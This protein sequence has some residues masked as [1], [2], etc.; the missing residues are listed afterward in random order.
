[1]LTY[2]G[3]GQWAHS[4][5]PGIIIVFYGSDFQANLTPIANEASDLENGN[6]PG[7]VKIYLKVF[8]WVIFLLPG[9]DQGL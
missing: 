4:H 9:R 3:E 2:M 5:F 7:A 8:Q 6:A 1:M